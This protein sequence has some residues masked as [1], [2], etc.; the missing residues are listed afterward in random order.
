M[1]KTLL[2]CLKNT[3]PEII[4]EYMDTLKCACKEL[5]KIARKSTMPKRVIL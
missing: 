5:E 4:K 2:R 3:H 1:D